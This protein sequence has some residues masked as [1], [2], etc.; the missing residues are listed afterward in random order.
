LFQQKEFIFDWSGFSDEGMGLLNGISWIWAAGMSILKTI[1][2]KFKLNNMKKNYSHLIATLLLSFCTSFLYSQKPSYVIQGPHTEYEGP[3]YIRVFVNYVQLPNDQW[4]TSVDLAARTAGILANLN[5]VYNPYHIYFVGQTTS[6]NATHGVITQSNF[7]PSHLHPDALDIF[8]SGDGAGSGA[9]GYAFGVPNTFCAVAGSYGTLSAGLSEVVIHEVAHC[10]GLSH[11]FTGTQ[12][13]ECLETGGLCTDGEPDCY[14]CG[15]YVCDTPFTP[16]NITVSTDCSQATSH[17]GMP[18]VVF[19][20]YMCYS[21]QPQ[22]RDRFTEGQV[23]R[24]WAYLALAPIL[25]PIQIQDVHY[26]GAT[27]PSVSGNIV[28]ESGE[29][30]INAALE[31]LPGA[32]IRVE[33]GAKLKIIAP[34]TGACGGMWQGIIV[35][36]STF[37]AQTAVNQGQVSIYG[38][39]ILEH[40][41]IAIDVQ[42]SDPNGVPL[43][44]TGGGIV[45]VVNGQFIN[46]TIGIRFGPYA[47]PGTNSANASFLFLPRISVND[48]YRGGD[49]KPTCIDLDGVVRLKIQYSVL[50][51]LRTICTGPATRSNGID[52]KNA[53][54]VALGGE[55]SGLDIGIRADQ[56]NL[57]NGSFTVSG[58]EFTSCYK[59]IQSISTSGFA[60]SGNTFTV[61]KPDVCPSAIVEIIGVQ[62]KG[63]TTGF[64][65]SDNDFAFNG[66]ASPNEILIGTDC[67]GLGEGLDNTIE[68][69][70]YT[71]LNIGNRAKGINFGLDDG[72]EYQCNTNVNSLGLPIDFQVKSGSIRS[73]QAGRL[74]NPNNP[75]IP[76]GNVFSEVSFTFENNGGLLNYYYLSNINHPFQDPDHVFGL[77]S[78]GI[79]PKD[80][81]IPN[82]ECD[83]P[84]PCYDCTEE[85]EE[86]L[87]QKFHENHS[88]WV[89]KKALLQTLSGPAEIEA[90]QKEISALRLAM[91]M[92]AGNILRNYEQDTIGITVD[93]IVHWLALT[94]TYQTD[95]RL[96]KHHFFNSNYTAFETLWSNLTAENT[97][98]VAQA[99]EVARLDSMF[100]YLKDQFNQGYSLNNLPDVAINFLT[101]NTLQCDEA[102]YLSEILLWRNGV[103]IDL[104]CNPVG[105]RQLRHQY[106]KRENEKW[107]SGYPN[108]VNEEFILVLG[109]NNP[110][111]VQVYDQFSRRVFHLAFGAETQNLPIN[112]SRFNSG[113]YFVEV[114]NKGERPQQLKFVV[115]H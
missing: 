103:R 39:G 97:L 61:K 70:T 6:C 36:G 53:G 56:L 32:T 13:G 20:N 26:P 69:N 30:T 7:M 46:N 67:E 104:D 82:L 72:L 16:Q 38:D 95:L 105:E 76:T 58:C 109:T 47:S 84:I 88:E 14:C 89:A 85:W 64:I 49:K 57:N 68:K 79:V 41:N 55:F 28:V 112:T 52:S 106:S 19:R 66:I 37:A 10:L 87:K 86:G 45:N 93:S 48:S 22:C 24:M 78:F 2:L 99:A 75:D 23:K 96:A 17:P 114:R 40:A 18:P 35:E 51:D 29:L 12:S 80:L 71:N 1:T 11:T 74:A 77:G 94:Q 42:D 31:M 65:F 3:Y 62:I 4:T 115:Q 5:T 91:N 8:D 92:D 43:N 15:D 27:P 9:T 111:T 63:N 60:I 59:E 108:P 90:V 54:F 113:V 21:T 50:R 25:Q 81:T 107:I 34:I 102:A 83:D 101:S 73:I 98:N 44:N 33:P 110:G 100:I